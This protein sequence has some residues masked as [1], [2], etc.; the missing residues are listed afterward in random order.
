[1]QKLQLIV[2]KKLKT[3]LAEKESRLAQH[4]EATKLQT[5]QKMALLKKV[6]V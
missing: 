5:D 3:E 2:V 4:A 6:T 1:M